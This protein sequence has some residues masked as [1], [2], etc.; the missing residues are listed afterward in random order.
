MKSPPMDLEMKSCCMSRRLE[1]YCQGWSPDGKSLT[2]M[3]VNNANRDIWTLPLSGDRKPVPYLQTEFSEQG[4][5]YSP[6]GKWIA[7]WSDE[8]GTDEVYLRSATRTGGKLLVFF[9]R[10]GHVPDG[11]GTARR[12]SI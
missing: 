2:L 7:Y 11:V 1:K 5:E 4:G 12:F 3:T 8:S 6:D 9:R 10:E